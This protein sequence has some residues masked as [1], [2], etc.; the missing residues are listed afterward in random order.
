V[1]AG[2]IVAENGDVVRQSNQRHVRQL[3]RAPRIDVFGDH[4]GIR[5][6]GAG[7]RRINHAL[8]M[9]AATHIRDPGTAGPRGRNGVPYLQAHP[10]GPPV[11][12]VRSVKGDGRNR[13]RLP[14]R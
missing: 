9:M 11:Q 3:Q 13:G 5:L 14:G 12:G 7:N 2:R 6:S 1:I 8:Y 4:I 10:V